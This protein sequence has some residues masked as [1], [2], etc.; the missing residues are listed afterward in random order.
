M[1]MFTDTMCW[2]TKQISLHRITIT[3]FK[4]LTNVIEISIANKKS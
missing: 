1:Q 2:E 4:T 3:L